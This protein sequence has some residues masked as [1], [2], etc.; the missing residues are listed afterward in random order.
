MSAQRKL[1]KCAI[2]SRV[3]T[4][5]QT[6]G[7]YNSLESQR[8]ICE[9]AIALHQHEGWASTHYFEDPGFSGKNLERPGIQQ[10]MAEIEAGHVNVVVAYKID[11]ITR[12]IGDFYQWWK[13]L[14]KRNVHFVSATQSFDTS[15][16]VGML[17]LNMLLSFGQFERELTA[18]R[19]SHKFAERAKKG[20]WN[21]GWVPYGYSHDKESK[22]L[23]VDPEEAPLIKQIFEL[24]AKLK[25]PTEVAKA[26]NNQGL[27]SKKRIVTTRAG[28]E[29]AIGG[30]RF[31]GDRVKRIVNNPIYKGVIAHDGNEYP[32]EHPALVSAKLWKRANEAFEN[33]EIRRHST[34]TS[35]NKHKQVLKGL[36][37]CG[38]CGNGLTPKPSG[39]KDPNGNPY[40]YYTCNE[41]SKDG[42]AAAC[43]LRNLPAR[44]FEKFVVEIISEMGKHPDVIKAALEASN[45]AKNKSV[46]KLK[47]KLSELSKKY[48]CVS[49]ELR[50]CLD[51]AK[52]EGATHLT[53]EFL[54]EAEDL[55]KT[56]HAIEAQREKVKMDINFQERVV[57]DEKLIAGAL[58]RF[59]DVYDT[60][61]FEE[62]QELLELVVKS[63][64]VRRFDPDKEKEPDEKGAFVTKMRTSWYLLKIRFYASDWISGTYGS[65]SSSSHLGQDGGG[66]GI[67]THETF[68]PAGFQDQCIQP[69]CHPSG[70]RLWQ[71]GCLPRIV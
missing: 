43:S 46:R 66:G 21:G 48:E 70:H 18:E 29:K 13:L 2:Y 60:L 63:I 1:L 8:D 10:L 3:S 25:S 30:K 50:V 71:C 49:G 19:V 9:H 17:M 31:I 42:K 26:L 44:P 54:A 34:S 38:E 37:R 33:P 59:A 53:D 69:L 4:D 6:R 41:V 40:L 55:A 28:K 16:P 14:E 24:A 51:A 65:G 7:E 39:K 67:R 27:R 32:G 61:P 62:Q 52:K 23:V 64:S 35:S 5:D 15:T 12:N 36:L 47:S 57:T 11:R 22:I 45:K 58:Q 56:K 20:M 68:R